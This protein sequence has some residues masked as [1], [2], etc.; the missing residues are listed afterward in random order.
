MT[1]LGALT[2]PTHQ[3]LTQG[4][5]LITIPVLHEIRK[6]LQPSW[7]SA[8][9]FCCCSFLPVLLLLLFHS[10]AQCCSV[11][12]AC[13][14]RAVFLCILCE[15]LFTWNCWEYQMPIVRD[16]CAI[17]RPAIL[18]HVYLFNGGKYAVR[19][20]YISHRIYKLEE[21]NGRYRVVWWALSRSIYC[22][23]F[24]GGGWWVHEAN[25]SR[26]AARWMDS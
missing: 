25:A 17:V 15:S 12:F 24:V 3:S 5:S 14:R 9:F 18:P 16:L 20:F 2:D 1:N 21:E 23:S 22:C 8:V 4:L 6:L 13:V 19:L 26:Q 10:R 7:L 11:L